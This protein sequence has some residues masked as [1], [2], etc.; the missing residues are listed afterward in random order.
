MRATGLM[1]ESQ[2]QTLQSQINQI[3]MITDPTKQQA[4]MSRIA[5]MTINSIGGEVSRGLGYMVDPLKAYK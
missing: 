4:A 5:R 2:I 1:S 3:K